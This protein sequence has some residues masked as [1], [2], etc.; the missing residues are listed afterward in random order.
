MEYMT[1]TNYV[2]SEVNRPYILRST[3]LQLSITIELMAMPQ[4]FY[5]LFWE[6]QFEESWKNQKVFEESAINA[7]AIKFA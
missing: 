7:R 1:H 3:R 6:N 5:F 2:E 4:I